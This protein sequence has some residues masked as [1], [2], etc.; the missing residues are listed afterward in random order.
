MS[1]GPGHI[2][3]AALGVVRGA[4]QPLESQEIARQVFGR[5]SLKDVTAPEGASVR[6]ALRALA[7]RGEVEDMGRNW[8]RKRRKWAT[9]EVAAQHRAWSRAFLEASEARRKASGAA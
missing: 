8:A 7:L 3:R 4:A 2:M 6:R 5:A 9:P 1:K